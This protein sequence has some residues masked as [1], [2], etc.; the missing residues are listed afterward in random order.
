MISLNRH[1]FIKTLKKATVYS[2][3]LFIVVF[4]LA[5]VSIL[6]AY[7]GNESIGIPPAHHTEQI[8]DCPDEVS[9][10]N[11]VRTDSDNSFTNHNHNSEDN[12][13]CN[14]ECLGNCSHIIL[15]YFEF[16]PFI[17]K[18][19]KQVENPLFYE[20]TIPNSESTSLFRPPQTA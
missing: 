2:V 16:L 7:C 1:N 20:N 3:A 18:E 5:E 9:Q 14:D 4:A 12:D 10:T 11:T 15:G 17:S 13:D 6:Q 19:T 8:K